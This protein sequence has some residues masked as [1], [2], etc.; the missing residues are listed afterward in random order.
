M[1]TT[2]YN[3]SSGSIEVARG[4]EGPKH[5]PYSYTRITVRRRGYRTATLHIGLGVWSYVAQRGKVVGNVRGQRDSERWHVLRF[6]R[7]CGWT[8]EQVHRAMWLAELRPAR[9]MAEQMAAIERA[10]YGD[11]T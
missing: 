11:V 7:A 10:Y 9:V 1:R 6:E 2:T 3:T 8:L 4:C 5:D